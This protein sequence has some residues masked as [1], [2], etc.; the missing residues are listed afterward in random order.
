MK[1]CSFLRRRYFA[2]RLK[3][4]LRCLGFELVLGPSFSVYIFVDISIS[5]ECITLLPSVVLEFSKNGRDWRIILWVIRLKLAISGCSKLRPS[6]RRSAQSNVG[7][8]M[9]SWFVKKFHRHLDGKAVASVP[10]LQRPGT[11]TT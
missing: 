2:G 7:Q 8:R 3:D 9:S 10:Y 1:T 5:N 11:D 4:E 6:A